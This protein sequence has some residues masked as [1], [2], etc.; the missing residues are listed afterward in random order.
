MFASGAKDGRREEKGQEGGAGAG[1]RG[2]CRLYAGVSTGD[3]RLGGA[4]IK[5]THTCKVVWHG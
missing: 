3:G 4:A 1:G 5:V 2:R